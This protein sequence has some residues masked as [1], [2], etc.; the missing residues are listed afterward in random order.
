M[1]II[2]RIFIKFTPAVMLTLSLRSPSRNPLINALNKRGLRVK[3]AMT[4]ES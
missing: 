3:P 4:K 1:E 2:C